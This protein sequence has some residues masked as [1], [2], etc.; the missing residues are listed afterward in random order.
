MSSG[1][2]YLNFRIDFF[3][4]CVAQFY[5]CYIFKFLSLFL[6]FICSSFVRSRSQKAETAE[7]PGSSSPVI[8]STRWLRQSQDTSFFLLQDDVIARST[9][10]SEWMDHISFSICI[11]D[12]YECLADRL[13]NSKAVSCWNYLCLSARKNHSDSSLLPINRESLQGFKP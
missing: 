2:N 13:R 1:N 10:T 9:L 5:A 4:W 8:W 11:P 12:P 3:F 6:Y 7:T